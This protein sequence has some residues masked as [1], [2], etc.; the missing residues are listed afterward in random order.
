MDTIT[1]SVIEFH[2]LCLYI[3][4]PSCEQQTNGEKKSLEKFHFFPFAHKRKQT[5]K[6]YVNL[7]AN[8]FATIEK[9]YVYRTMLVA[10]AAVFVHSIQYLTLS[11]KSSTYYLYL[12]MYS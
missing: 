6:Q 1:H 7:C 11:C 3:L 2:Y 12:Q 9:I 5:N 8:S 4:W 10:I